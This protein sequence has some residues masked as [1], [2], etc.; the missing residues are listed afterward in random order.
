[1][2][3]ALGE[4]LGFLL[5]IGIHLYQLGLPFGY[6]DRGNIKPDKTGTKGRSKKNFAVKAVLQPQDYAKDKTND[7]SHSKPLLVA[8][9]LVYILL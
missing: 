3:G 2:P 8:T 7:Q 5:A 4:R 6:M 9:G 1:M